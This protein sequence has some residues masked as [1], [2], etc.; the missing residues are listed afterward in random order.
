MSH[1]R[2]L[3]RNMESLIKGKLVSRRANTG[4]PSRPHPV[5]VPAMYFPRDVAPEK[6]AETRLRRFRGAYASKRL[7]G[8][9]AITAR[10]GDI[11]FNLKAFRFLEYYI[12]LFV[13]FPVIMESNLYGS[14]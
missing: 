1:G 6:A 14:R 8:C 10:S 13:F 11:I 3:L 5:A 12:R 2:S 4:R 9:A 7:S